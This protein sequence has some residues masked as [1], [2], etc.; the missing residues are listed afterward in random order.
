MPARNTRDL[1]PSPDRVA[2]GRGA[3]LQSSGAGCR[4]LQHDIDKSS[5]AGCRGLQHGVELYSTRGE[6]PNDVVCQKWIADSYG[7]PV[8]EVEQP[9]KPFAALNRRVAVGW[10]HR[11]F[12]W[13]EQLV[14]HA[15]VVALAVIVHD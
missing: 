1:L 5:G 3:S 4:G 14:T 7:A 9:A 2:P 13:C 6:D 10:S 8:V 11:S 12:G 15:L